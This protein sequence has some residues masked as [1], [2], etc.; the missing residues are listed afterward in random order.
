MQ[1]CKLQEHHRIELEAFQSSFHKELAIAQMLFYCA[2]ENIC[3]YGPML[4]TVAALFC[5]LLQNQKTNQRGR[6]AGPILRYRQDYW[7]LE[8]WHAVNLIRKIRKKTSRNMKFLGKQCARLTRLL[9]YED[10]KAKC[11]DDAK[12]RDLRE[13]LAWRQYQFTDEGKWQVWLKNGTFECASRSLAG[14]KARAGS[15]AMRASFMRVEKKLKDPTEPARY[16]FFEDRF[17]TNLGF[18][19][20]HERKPGTKSIPL[21]SRTA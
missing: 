12:M 7:D 11:R 21:Y 2:E 9:K 15:D 4:K 14:R 8:R 1:L 20:L 5:E 6:T 3:V 16:I 17:L 13:E 10:G 19:P 18:S